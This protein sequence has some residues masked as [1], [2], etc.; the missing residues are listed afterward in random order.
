MHDEGEREERE[1]GVVKGSVSF[2]VGR[3]DVEK[4]D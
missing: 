2:A 4:L 3:V 1:T